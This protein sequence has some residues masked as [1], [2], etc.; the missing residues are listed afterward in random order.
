M[1][2]PTNEKLLSMFG[3]M[4]RIKTCDEKLRRL[5][6]GGQL[7]IAYFSPRGQEV[8]AAALGEALAPDDYLVTTYRGLHDSLAKGVPLPALWAEYLGRADGPCKGKGGPMHLTDV[9]HGVMVTTGMVGS[10]LPIAN[11]LALSSQLRD[12]GRVTAVTFGDGASNIGGFHEALNLAAVWNLP[13]VFVCQ[14]NGYAEMTARRLTQRTEHIADRAAAYGMPGVTV[15]G[16]DWNATFDVLNEAVARARDGGGPTLVEACTYRFFGHYFGDQMTYQDAAER[17]AAV[18]AD[19]VPAMRAWLV[20]QGT[21]T[22][23]ELAAIETAQAAAVDE[24]AAAALA[25]EVPSLAE[26]STDVYAGVR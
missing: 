19:P 24:A 26:L 23:A 9:E 25:A 8:V 7:M 12:D 17:E 18:A 6:M 2:A 5:I 16:N 11:G 20:E 21:A 14:N 15:D 4:T 1:A 3:T 10:G 13:A 22:E